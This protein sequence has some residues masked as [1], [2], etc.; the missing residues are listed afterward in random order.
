M[1]GMKPT[2]NWRPA[3]TDSKTD[4]DHIPPLR[5]P[6]ALAG[7]ALGVSP[8]GRPRASPREGP[9]AQMQNLDEDKLLISTWLNVSLDVVQD[10]SSQAYVQ[11]IVQ[12]F[13]PI[14]PLL[15]RA[16]TTTKVDGLSKEEIDLKGGF[17]TIIISFSYSQFSLHSRDNQP[18]RYG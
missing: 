2:G 8:V 12:R 9:Q 13:L 7:L 11:V 3:S 10:W 14:Y 1:R 15:E 4:F 18:Q 17:E 5:S 6:A 16:S